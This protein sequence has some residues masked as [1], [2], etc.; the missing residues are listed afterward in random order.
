MEMQT[1]LLGGV[2]KDMLLETIIA[3]LRVVKL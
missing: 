3:E 2:R 1:R